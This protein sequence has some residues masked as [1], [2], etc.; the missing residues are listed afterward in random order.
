SAWLSI[1]TAIGFY[2]NMGGVGIPEKLHNFAIAMAEQ[3]ANDWHVK[4][5]ATP[6]MFGSMVTLPVPLN[7]GVT[8]EVA[9][10]WRDA[11]WQENRIEVPFF[12]INGQLW[13]RISAQL[14]NSSIDYEQ[15]SQVISS[16]I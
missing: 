14:Y 5:P 16:K 12:A 9:N 7:G 11:L 10:Q 13:L 8:Q 4:L 6:A 15:L 2:N 3:L 1:S